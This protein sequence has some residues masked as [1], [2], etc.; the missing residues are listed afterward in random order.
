MREAKRGGG[1]GIGERGGYS[2]AGKDRNGVEGRS[3]TW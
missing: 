3:I 1:K 2:N